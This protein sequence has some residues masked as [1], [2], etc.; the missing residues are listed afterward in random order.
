MGATDDLTLQR[1]LLHIRQQQWR[2][3]C[4]ENFLAFATEALQ[5][6][7]QKPARHHR[8]MCAELEAVARGEVRRLIILAPPGSA[9]TTYA[10]R[11]L[12]AWFFA[13]RANANIIG[14]SHTA[15]LA[16]TNSTY[17]QRYVRDNAGLLG[18][19]LL[20]E[21]RVNW[22]TTNGGRYRAVGV[23][24]AITGFRADLVILDDPIRGRDD[25]ESATQREQLWGW[26]SADLLTR[27]KPHGAVA[28]IMTPYHE[29]DLAG[30]L[31]R[32]QSSEWRILRLPAIAE[33]GDALGRTEGEPL[34][35]DDADYGYGG[36]LLDIYAEMERTGRL[37]DWYALYQGRPRPPE[38]AMFLPGRIPVLDFIAQHTVWD[39]ARAWDFAASIK[40]DWSVG[41]KLVS[42]NG[43]QGVDYIISDVQ[44]FRG[45]P[46]EVHR[47]V[48]AIAEADGYGTRIYVPQ[49]PGSAGV[50]QAESYIRGLVGYAIAAERMTGDKA[51]RAFAVAAQVNIGRIG[52]LKAPWNAIFLDELGSFPLGQHDDQV[53]ALAY[54]FSKLVRQDVSVWAR[55]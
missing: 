47:T 16:E 42:V 32:L 30:R 14:A 18:Y 28:V 1:R 31:Q 15:E 5:P 35:D 6:F 7:G 26:F 17:V 11:L 48:K 23:G 46:D 10:S 53:D 40:G 54:A 22:E 25:A 55:F 9:K 13:D 49:D 4:C 36:R 2:Q 37:R 34:W 19:G 12:P 39:R 44:R 52:M 51:S 8:R 41:L 43:D 50:D 29:D 24:G 20:S 33:I 21:S 45:R 38:G 3:F 27:L